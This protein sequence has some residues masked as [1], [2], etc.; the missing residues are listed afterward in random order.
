M[1]NLRK[2]HSRAQSGVALATI[3][4]LLALA[5]VD[6][7]LA[8]LGHGTVEPIKFTNSDS[9]RLS[10]SRVDVNALPAIET[11]VPDGPAW[12]AGD[13]D[14]SVSVYAAGGGRPG[15]AMKI[16]DPDS[17]PKGSGQAVI[18]VRPQEGIINENAVDGCVPPSGN[19]GIRWISTSDSARP[20]L[21]MPSSLV[22]AAR[23]C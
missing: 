4:L 17:A 1:L 7:V 12:Y 18:P 15:Y 11:A 21:E 10:T 19:G 8:Q 22:Q 9:D 13:F 16:L 6:D 23:F 2:A 5:G 14:V 3:I 20:G